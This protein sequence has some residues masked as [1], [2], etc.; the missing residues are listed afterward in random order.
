MNIKKIKDGNYAGKTYTV[1]YEDIVEAAEAIISSVGFEYRD[2]QD[3]K[4]NVNLILPA[5]VVDG[6]VKEAYRNSKKNVSDSRRIK[7]DETPVYIV[8]DLNKDVRSFDN[9]SDAIDFA[10]DLFTR[11]KRTIEVE[12]VYMGKDTD[13]H[14]IVWSSDKVSDSRVSDDDDAF[15]EYF[16]YSEEAMEENDKVNDKCGG[17]RK[18]RDYAGQ[19]MVSQYYDFYQE[20]ANDMLQLVNTEQGLSFK[21]AKEMLED[22]GLV[23]V[24]YGGGQY[25]NAYACYAFEDDDR[26]G[27]YGNAGACIMI[28]YDNNN[29]EMLI[30]DIYA[31]E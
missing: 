15:D 13:A 31:C 6:A 27:D 5:N 18:V 19:P 20:M 26:F 16:D 28:E 17:K 25:G 10:K 7:D 9:K 21:K 22:E 3:F 24:E 1:S 4:A 29:D 12:E 30:T 2:L 8:Y 14:K 11:K 23:E